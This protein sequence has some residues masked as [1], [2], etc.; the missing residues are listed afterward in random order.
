[1]AGRKTHRHSHESRERDDYSESSAADQRDA[2][3]SGGETQ[4]GNGAVGTV[5][6]VKVSGSAPSKEPV[7]QRA[8]ELADRLGERISH[9]ASLLGFKFLQFVARAREEAEDIWAEAQNIRSS[10]QPQRPEP[11]PQG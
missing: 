3:H 1:M 8:E 4:E 7:M 11:P 9:Y 6:E 2:A 5:Q 10:R